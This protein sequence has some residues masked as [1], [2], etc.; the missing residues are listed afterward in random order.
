MSVLVWD[1]VGDRFYD[2]GLDRGVLYLSDGSIVPWNGLISVVEKFDRDIT[3]VYYDGIKISDS[4]SLGDF[5]ATMKA[6]TYPEEFIGLEGYGF[7]RKG[8][9]LGDQLPQTFGLSYRTRIGNDAEGDVGY[10]IHILYNLTAIPTD[11]T[12]E[13]LNDSPNIVEFEWDISSIP[14]NIPGFRPTAHVVLSSKEIEPDLLTYI[15]EKLYGSSELDPAFLDIND[16][17]SYMYTWAR[18]DII[19][20]S[21]GT[22]T[23]NCLFDEDLVFG[24]DGLFTID[25]DVQFLDAV[26]YT[27]S[28]TINSP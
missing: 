12:H 4:V 24:E 6:Y 14:E 16:L 11:R 28:N 19:D 26:T 15:E 5:S 13:T 9:A 7:L 8:L 23:A 20:N 18:I 2:T 22:W 25:G 3:S 1:K 17:I 10:K 21:D 27:I